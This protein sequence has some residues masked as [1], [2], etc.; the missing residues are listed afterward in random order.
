MRRAR[1]FSGIR[2][3]AG[4]LGIRGEELPGIAAVVL[5]NPEAKNL[6]KAEVR[7]IL[8]TSFE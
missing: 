8:S 5:R 4:A 2:S 6:S 7:E 3:S 1:D